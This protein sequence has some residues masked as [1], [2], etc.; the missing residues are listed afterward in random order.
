[1][2]NAFKTELIVA[3]NNDDSLSRVFDEHE[4]HGGPFQ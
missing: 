4:G 1:M 3:Q 2:I